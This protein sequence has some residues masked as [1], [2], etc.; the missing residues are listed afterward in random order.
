LANSKQE[1][2]VHR[3]E[4]QERSRKQRKARARHVQTS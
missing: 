1:A 4:E 3:S 2:E